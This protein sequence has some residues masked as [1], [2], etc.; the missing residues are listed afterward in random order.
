MTTG[1]NIRRIRKERGLTQKQLG[2]L[3]G[4]NEANIRKYELGNQNPKIDTI[5]KIAIALGVD[6]FSLCSFK[7]ATPTHLSSEEMEHITKYRTLD[8]AGKFHVNTVLNWEVA[9]SADL[10]Q[11]QEH[12]SNLEAKLDSMAPDPR[13]VLNAAH[14]R[15]DIPVTEEMRQA[16]DDIMNDENF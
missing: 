5:Q 14:E 8:P 7:M 3:C 9:R 4:I 10:L 15:T 13:I 16:D 2:E 12:I 1:E 6:P 11:T